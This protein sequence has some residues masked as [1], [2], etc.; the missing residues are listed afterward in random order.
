MARTKA[1]AIAFTCLILIFP[2]YNLVKYEKVA[3]DPN[4]SFMLKHSEV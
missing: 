3:G 2:A 4:R 1:N